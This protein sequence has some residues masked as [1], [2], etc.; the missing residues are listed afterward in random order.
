MGIED[1]SAPTPDESDDE[2]MVDS[3]RSRSK[4]SF[5]YNDLEA[6]VGLADKLRANAGSTAC[7]VK[8][9]ATW[10]NQSAKGGTF[11]STLG[12]ARTFGLV[13]TQHGG[14]VSLTR[15]GQN[16]IDEDERS[17]AVANAFLNVPLHTALYQQYEGNALPPSPAIERHIESLG[18]PSKQ[19]ERARQ[20]FTKSAKYAGFI[21]SSNGRFRRPA[22]APSVPAASAS[23]LP[24][25]GGDGRGGGLNLDPLLVA[26]LEKIPTVGDEWPKGQRVRWFRTFAMNVSQVYDT[27]DEVVDLTITVESDESEFQQVRATG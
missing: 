21:D 26:L 6:A 4:I 16:V 18:V 1:F 5:V 27:G 13:E 24:K 17:N 12:A 22:T 11:R 2:Q 8:Q 19:K 20:T 3:S 25:G 10:M 15:L 9:L 23:V 14:T 7:A